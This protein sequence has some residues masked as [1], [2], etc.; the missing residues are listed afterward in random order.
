MTGATI[1][2]HP[3][4]GTSRR[5]LEAIRAAGIEPEVVEYRKTPPSRAALAEAITTA[6]LTPR[7]AIRRKEGAALLADPALDDAALLD[8]MVADPAL[9]ER[10]FVF[11]PAGV[12]LCR[13]AERLQE[14]LPG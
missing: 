9:I 13:P 3:A 5:V 4:C 12:R 14:I 8:A 10:P 6:G 11:T 7:L 2:H 1:W